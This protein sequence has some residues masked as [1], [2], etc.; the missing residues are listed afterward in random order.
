M[1]SIPLALAGQIA[2]A[3]WPFIKAAH[4]AALNAYAPYSHFAV[5]AAVRTRGGSIYTG[6]NLENAAYGVGMCAEM[7]AV[8]AANSA[9]DFEIEAIAVTGWTFWPKR[10]GRMVVTPCGR[11]RQIICEAGQSAG[12]DVE[13][14]CCNGDLTEVMTQPISALLPHA[15][16]PENLGITA[17]WRQMRAVL[18]TQ[19]HES[20]AA[21]SHPSHRLAL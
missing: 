13:I 4:H 1:E 17:S 16:G 21:I 8:A 12:K 14:L 2:P 6:A 7:A 10:D 11:C 19:G 9:G 15:F 20:E 3:D 18:K 5:G